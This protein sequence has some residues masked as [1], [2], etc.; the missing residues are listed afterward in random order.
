[1]VYGLIKHSS[2][3]AVDSTER[4]R[5]ALHRRELRQHQ[6]HRHQ[7]LPRRAVERA[8]AVAPLGILV[9]DVD[10][11]EMC[12]MGGADR[13]HEA[14]AVTF[15]VQDDSFVGNDGDDDGGDIINDDVF[16]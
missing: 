3:R 9:K 8:L 10:K 12:E 1:M 15:L 11:L 16:V 2:Q 14:K 4:E 6:H 5:H 7:G 13:K